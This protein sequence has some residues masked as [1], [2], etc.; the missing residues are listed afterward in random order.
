MDANF[1]RLSR[2]GWK[3]SD[4]QLPAAALAVLLTVIVSEQWTYF[5][6]DQTSFLAWHTILETVS[7]AV[8]LSIALQGWLTLPH[9]MSRQML[10][11]AA[12]FLGVGLLDSVHML[13]A[14]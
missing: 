12:V 9:T 13:H 2:S 3:W 4:L 1:A 6:I 11:L 14:A 7:I 5:V 10:L 8:S